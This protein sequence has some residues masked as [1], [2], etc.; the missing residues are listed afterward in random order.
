MSP[1]PTEPGA[2]DAGRLRSLI[3]A[4]SAVGRASGGTSELRS[5]LT[6]EL[7][8]SEV[9]LPAGVAI[10]QHVHGSSRELARVPYDGAVLVVH[11]V[12]PAGSSF[13]VHDEDGQPHAR[14]GPAVTLH[15]PEDLS[16][17]ELLVVFAA[18]LG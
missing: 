8:G 17:D 14:R 15:R 13:L 4:H 6:S 9:V 3:D 1:D 11:N 12:E 16:H 7:V 18:D 5:R 2:I 10:W